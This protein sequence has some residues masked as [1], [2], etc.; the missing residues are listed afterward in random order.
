MSDFLEL[1]RS[2]NWYDNSAALA[3]LSFSNYNVLSNT[4]GTGISTFMSMM[5]YFLNCKY[6]T[7]SI[8]EHL[9]ISGRM[10]INEWCNRSIVIKLDF[11][12]FDS[13][14]YGD[15]LRYITVKMADLYK[16]HKDWFLLEKPQTEYFAAALFVKLLDGEIPENELQMSL[17]SILWEARQQE[18]LSVNAKEKKPVV[19]LIDN[20]VKMEVVSGKNHFRDAMEDFLEKFIVEDVYDFCDVFVQAGG[21][22]AIGDYNIWNNLERPYISYKYFS[23]HETDIRYS[24]LA[25]LIVP[26]EKQY[27]KLIRAEEYRQENWEKIL[28]RQR[29]LVTES[30]ELKTGLKKAEK[31]KEKIRYAQ[32]LTADFPCVSSNLGIREFHTDTDNAQYQKLNQQLKKLF[33]QKHKDERSLYEN[34]QKLNRESRTDAPKDAEEYFAA[35]I[36]KTAD[37]YDFKGQANTDD[38]WDTFQF[39]RKDGGCPADCNAV[40]VYITFDSMAIMDRF[41]K[42]M[43]HLLENASC[44]FAAKVSKFERVDQICIWIQPVDYVFLAQ[45]CQKY[46]EELREDMQFIA[47]SDG[48]GI[49]KDFGIDISHNRM[50]AKL[51]QTYFSTISQVEEVSLEKMYD[52]FVQGWN[53]QLPENHIFQREFKKTSVISLLVMMDTLNVLLGKERIDD[54]SMLLMN[55]PV[56]WKEFQG[57]RCWGDLNQLYLTEGWQHLNTIGSGL[58]MVFP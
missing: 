35:Y 47:Y 51:I 33:E 27:M 32:N 49:S 39:F 55:N 13:E 4:A 42:M 12:D 9:A 1:Y 6:D 14:T 25:N 19:F 43:L 28:K 24:R 26:K 54:T 38:Y 5:D 21:V 3:G 8:F 45:F 48:L 30:I 7:K 15:A 17:K 20:L 2:G 36:Q 18:R 31:E 50:Q 57:S 46:R 22:A 41:A 34:F 58:Q 29:Q 44:S 56:M 37:D 53:G 23:I 11:S 52:L 16:E 40:K 10:D